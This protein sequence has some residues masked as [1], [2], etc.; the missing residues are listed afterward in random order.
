MG[1]RYSY[2][3]RMLTLFLVV[4]IRHPAFEVNLFNGSGGMAGVLK[5]LNFENYLSL[6]GLGMALCWKFWTKTVAPQ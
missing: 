4:F 1:H 6:F 2:L 5:L 3:I